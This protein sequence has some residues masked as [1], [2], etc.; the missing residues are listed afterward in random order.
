MHE[1]PNSYLSAFLLMVGIH[2][3]TISR[4]TPILS[5]QRSLLGRYETLLRQGR[6]STHVHLINRIFP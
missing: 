5:L 6:N 3:L 4:N 1:T 2:A